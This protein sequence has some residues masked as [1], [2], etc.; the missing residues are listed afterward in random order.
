M[1]YAIPMPEAQ[2]QHEPIHEPQ[3]HAGPNPRGEQPAAHPDTRRPDLLPADSGASPSAE[4][5]PTTPEADAPQQPETQALLPDLPM[6]VIL[7]ACAHLDPNFLACCVRLTCKAA[8][9]Q[10]GSVVRLSKPCPEHAFADHWGR[11][12]STRHLSLV[13]RRRL[14]CLVA[15]SGVGPN[16]RVA[17]AAADCAVPA[18]ALAA[19]AAAGHVEVCELLWP[20][21]AEVL[22]SS[23]GAGAGAGSGSRSGGGGERHPSEMQPH[24]NVL[25]ERLARSDPLVAAARAGRTQV[26]SWL[27]TRAEQEAPSSCSSRPH[28]FFDLASATLA[29]VLGGNAALYRTLR[30]RLAAATGHSKPL[31]PARLLA[32]LAE[33]G[34]LAAL[35]RTV[36][37][38]PPALSL[39]AGSLLSGGFDAA[40]CSAVLAAAARSTTPDWLDKVDFLMGLRRVM[41]EPGRGLLPWPRPGSP[42]HDAVAEAVLPRPVD[43]CPRLNERGLWATRSIAGLRAVAAAG[44]AG[45]LR[46]LLQTERLLGEVLQG[47]PELTAALDA[48]GGWGDRGRP[49]STVGFSPAH[50]AAACTAAAVAAAEANQL[51]CLH[52]ALECAPRAAH[53]AAL[54]AAL[55]SGHVAMAQWLGGRLLPTAP[56][57]AAS[58][59]V[60]VQLLVAAAESG[61]LELVRW[62][63]EERHLQRGLGPEVF[64]AAVRGG[65]CELMAWLAAQGCDEGVRGVMG[66]G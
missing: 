34:N 43:H 33:A 24:P 60:A 2:A 27:L 21:V 49:Q 20:L 44:Q 9:S 62:L 31:P 45:I 15:A 65:G 39:S 48:T 32:A 61:S 40:G 13:Q 47:V 11:P 30:D 36:A 26:C 35:G 55:R 25:L 22:R 52:V 58:M 8:A 19:A 12:G 54:L 17:V 66:W 53:K 10:L 1:D 4:L 38:L 3:P 50:Y 18:E 63:T 41:Q 23:S 29:A 56:P 57:P 5:R 46:Q 37:L 6:E 59:H 64:S 42:S 51:Q 7:Q 16:V 28:A 14:I